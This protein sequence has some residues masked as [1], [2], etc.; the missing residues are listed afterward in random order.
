M[1]S[2]ATAGT[3]PVRMLF[4][5]APAGMERMFGEIGTR[6][7]PGKPAPPV[8]PEDVAKL[9]SVAATYQFEV[10]EPE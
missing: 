9:L 7:P 8:T 2:Y 10:V 6:A 1:H 3:V 5:Y 4:L